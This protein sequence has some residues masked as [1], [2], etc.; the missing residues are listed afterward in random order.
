VDIYMP[1]LKLLSPELSK[2]YLKAA[3]YPRVA[4]EALKEMHRQVGFLQ[5]GEDGLARRGVLIRHL[6]LPGYPGETKE[7]LSWIARE[8]GPKSHVNVMGQYRPGG[9]VGRGKFPE[10][11]RPLPS[12]EYRIALDIARDAGLTLLDRH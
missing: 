3:D 2:R 10:L 7:V 4:R 9:V 11:N 5:I 6:V 12:S 1:D 8:L